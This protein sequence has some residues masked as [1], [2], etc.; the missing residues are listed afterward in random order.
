MTYY[1]DRVSLL[2]DLYDNVDLF[3]LLNNQITRYHFNRR[4][5]RYV[6]LNVAMEVNTEYDVCIDE[7]NT[8]YLI[9][10]DVNYN[11]I[12]AVIKN[13]KVNRIKLADAP[14]TEVYYMNVIVQ[15]G[16]IHIFYFAP[17]GDM[18][19][20]KLYHHHFKDQNWSVEVI[21]EIKVRELLN[22]LCIHKA[23]DKIIAAYLDYN[24]KEEQIY[25]KAYRVEDE[26]WEEKIQLTDGIS[27]KLYLDLIYRD[28]K[29][30]LTYCQYEEGNL[31]IKYERFNY[32]D[33]NISKE[34]E[35][36]IS[37]FGS[38]QD[39]TLIYF[40]DRLWIS[41]I[42][43]EKVYSRFSEDNGNSWS[44]IYLWK[45]S[46]KTSIVRY[47]YSSYKKDD[48]VIFNYSFGKIKDDIRFIGFGPLDNVEEV[49]LKKNYPSALLNS[50]QAEEVIVQ[51]DEF[52]KK[53]ELIDELNRK[54][55]E[56]ENNLRAL[57]ER[58]E[59]IE[60]FLS[61]RSRR[62]FR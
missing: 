18:E 32:E 31:V 28:K 58:I 22:L 27:N 3:R 60:E 50:P 59:Y 48:E 21:D 23:E 54:I 1:K 43:H 62:F 47:K 6:E 55:I 33:G 49:P 39:P 10:Q 24:S 14:I 8:I 4:T 15:N 12:L 26:K 56:L 16:Q 53:I 7:E 19:K 34:T 2:T 35:E 52:I 17:E 61:R 57:T 41:W 40:H 20:Y 11:I 51:G 44:P 13:N 36:I 29:L 30:H 5:N 45:D 37:N 38:Q 9:Y 42:E 46:A 25:I